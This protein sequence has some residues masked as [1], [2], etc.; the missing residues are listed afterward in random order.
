MDCAAR[1]LL[2]GS[3]DMLIVGGVNTNL[4]PESFVGFSKMGTL[5]ANGSFPFDERADGFILGEGAGV[6]VLKR[7]KDALRDKDRIYGTIKGMG[8][9]SDGKGK[10]IAAP[11]E[12]GQTVALE[13][14][15]ENIRTDV[16]AGDID[17]VEAH[18]TAT[19]IGDKVELKTL[20]NIYGNRTPI[21]ISSVKSQ[22]GHLLGVPVWPV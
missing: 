17:Y 18:G 22:I 1:E 2:S 20:K 5:S 14:C 13:R 9:S 19:M 12:K 15:F 4:T 7:M 3:H 10:A 6:I 8:S 11:S 21:G 16:T